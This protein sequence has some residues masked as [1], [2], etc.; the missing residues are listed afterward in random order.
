M[1]LDSH[2]RGSQ[3]EREKKGERRE[4]EGEGKVGGEREG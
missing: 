2:A 3:G 1:R 4:G